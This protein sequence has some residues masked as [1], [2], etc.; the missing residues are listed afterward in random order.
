VKIRK[1]LARWAPRLLHPTFCRNNTGFD[2]R[3][4]AKGFGPFCFF[5]P[6]QADSQKNLLFFT[7]ILALVL[8]VKYQIVVATG[9]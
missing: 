2:Q 7:W 1:S 3:L 8:L 5:E 9:N 4:E 6:R